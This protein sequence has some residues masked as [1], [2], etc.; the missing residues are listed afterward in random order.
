MPQTIILRPLESL[1]RRSHINYHHVGYSYP[2]RLRTALHPFLMNQK[3][4]LLK[5]GSGRLSNS[6]EL[7]IITVITTLKTECKH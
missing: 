1:S 3:E 7:Q 2:D 5:S 6:N 4:S